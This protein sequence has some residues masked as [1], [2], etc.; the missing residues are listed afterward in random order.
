MTIVTKSWALINRQVAHEVVEPETVQ[1]VPT[2]GITLNIIAGENTRS[3]E[4]NNGWQTLLNFIVDNNAFGG[5]NTLD[6]FVQIPIGG[7]SSEAS[8][9]SGVSGVGT[10]D[11]NHLGISVE[12][13]LRP[14]FGTEILTALVAYCQI[15]ARDN[16]LK[17]V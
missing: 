12:G 15:A 8:I 14:L 4:I 16:Y 10:Y 1:E 17:L 7:A 6:L 11:D 2:L 13:S 3:V 9:I 5:D